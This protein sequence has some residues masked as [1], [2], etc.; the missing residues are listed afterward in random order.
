MHA[1]VNMAESKANDN[2]TFNSAVRSITYIKRELIYVGTRKVILMFK[3]VRVLAR[4]RQN[5][6]VILDLKNHDLVFNSPVVRERDHQ[7]V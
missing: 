6:N 5:S 1:F 3:N 4:F 7:T 2:E